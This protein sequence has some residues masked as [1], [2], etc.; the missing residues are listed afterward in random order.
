MERNADELSMLSVSMTVDYFNMCLINSC[1]FFCIPN[2]K[3]VVL[4]WQVLN[5]SR[6]KKKKIKNEASTPGS[7][8]AKQ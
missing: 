1:F 6:G 4:Y 2:I 7:R 3:L 5:S 8:K